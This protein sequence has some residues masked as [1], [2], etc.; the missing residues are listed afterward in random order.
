[1]Y[2]LA[3]R[4]QW[5]TK[6]RPGWK[7]AYST[8]F[9]ENPRFQQTRALI[10]IMRTVV[11]QL[12]NTPGAGRHALIGAE[13]ID[14]LDT[15]VTSG[16]WQING[17]LEAAIAHDIASQGGQTAAAYQGRARE[18]YYLELA[19]EHFLDW[20]RTSGLLGDVIFKGGTGCEVRGI[21]HR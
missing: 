16:I 17:T 4:A 19:Q 2:D 9:K 10:R 18:E 21:R 6:A 12:W 14:L 5:R 15:G 3:R 13:D 7:D 11:A 1:M 8:R 20:M